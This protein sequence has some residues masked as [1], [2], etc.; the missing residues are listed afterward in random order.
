MDIQETDDA[1][2]RVN[3]GKPILQQPAYAGIEVRMRN[4]LEAYSKTGRLLRACATAGIAFRTHYRKLE[5]DPV[6]RAAF[7]EAEQ[8]A[9][10]NIEDK[11]YDMAI[12]DDNLPAAIVLL[13]RFRP[14][15][16]RER[17]SVEV[18]GNIDLI[19]R[20]KAAEERLITLKRDDLPDIAS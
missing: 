8:T 12:D 13:K 4:F 16:Y 9:A 18:S 14:N 15:L 20:M 2:E 19:E 11:V 10:Q 1:L 6:Y 3:K 5:S 7:E 17:S